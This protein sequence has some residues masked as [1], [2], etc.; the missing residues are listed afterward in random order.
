[1]DE[2]RAGTLHLSDAELTTAFGSCALPAAQFHHADH[3]RVAWIYV[4]EF[5]EAEAAERVLAGIKRFADHNGSPGKFHVTRT[6]TWMALVAESRRATP[7]I[8]GFPEFAAAHPHLFDAQRLLHFY[9]R[10]RLESHDARIG[11]MEPDRRPLPR[12]MDRSHK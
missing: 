7:E 8:C 10:D 6:L 5:G 12:C 3:V 1:M 11:W 4:R 2:I 9:S